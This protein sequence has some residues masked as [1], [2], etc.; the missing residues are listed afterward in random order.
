L[1]GNTL[2]IPYTSAGVEKTYFYTNCFQQDS[3][4]L[5]GTKYPGF[6]ITLKREWKNDQHSDE[7]EV[8]FMNSYG[9]HNTGNHMEFVSWFAP[10][11]ARKYLEWCIE[12]EE[13]ASKISI[14]DCFNLATMCKST[15]AAAHSSI[16]NGY[17]CTNKKRCT[18]NNGL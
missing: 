6:A 12:Q 2:Y 8:E 10:K 1:I 15:H 17:C 18:S 13:A 9:E 11:L 3:F 5:P 14:T 16:D 4:P 7:F